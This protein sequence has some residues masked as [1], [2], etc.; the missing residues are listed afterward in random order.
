MTAGRPSRLAPLTRRSERAPQSIRALQFVVCG[1][2]LSL[3]ALSC[4]L[5]LGL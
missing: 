4:L 5:E 3:L 1:T 2:P